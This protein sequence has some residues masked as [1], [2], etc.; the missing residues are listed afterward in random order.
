MLDGVSCPYRFTGSY[1]LAKNRVEWIGRIEWGNLFIVCI[2]CW[3]NFQQVV[4]FVTLWWGI[5]LVRSTF[6]CQS[7]CTSNLQIYSVDRQHLWNLK[8]QTNKMS[9]FHIKFLSTTNHPPNSGLTSS[10]VMFQH[11]KTSMNQT[12]SR[13]H[14]LLISMYGRDRLTFSGFWHFS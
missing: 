1:T 2:I 14:V 10:T 12:V 8:D 5:L 9:K 7:M 4:Y 11:I 6:F 13:Q 3:F